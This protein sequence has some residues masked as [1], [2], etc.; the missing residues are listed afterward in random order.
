MLAV[1]GKPLTLTRV[2]LSKEEL[3]V[4]IPGALYEIEVKTSP[5]TAEKAN[6]LLN[7]IREE[8]EARA[9][10]VLSI[11]V[12]ADTTKIQVKGSPF[13][14]AEILALLPTI[15][16]VLGITILIIAVYM[17]I[18]AIPSWVWAT[19]AIAA[20]LL[21]FTPTIQKIIAEAMKP[22]PKKR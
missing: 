11:Q 10:K 16:A 14:W 19:I 17:L 21:Y 7:K 3:T 8:L 6:Q 1:Y 15:F 18:A 2:A 12:S 20:L 4:S 5:V 22:K 13:T 9:I